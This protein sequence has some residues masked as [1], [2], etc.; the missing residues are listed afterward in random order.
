MCPSAFKTGLPRKIRNW[1]V[2][3]TISVI[4]I[5]SLVLI[6]WQFDISFF[7]RPLPDSKAMNPVAAVAF[8]FA[9][10]SFFALTSEPLAIRKLRTGIF[11]AALVLLI[12]TLKLISIVFS[13]DFY[14]DILLFQNKLGSDRMVPIAAINFMLTGI[15]LLLLHTK[16]KR[17][18]VTLNA[19]LLLIAGTSLFS[20]LGY[21]YQ[22]R[23][24]YGPFTYLPMAIHA[25]LGFLFLSVAMLFFNS[26]K[27]LMTEITGS[28]TGSITARKLIPVAILVPVL[29]GLLL[30]IGHWTNRFTPEFGVTILVFS[31]ILVLMGFIWHNVV[32]LN[33]REFQSR[34]AENALSEREEQIQTIFKAAPDAVIVIDH[35]GCI[36]QWNAKAELIFGWSSDEIIGKL[37][38]ETIIPERYREA[39][40]EGL[41]RFMRTG[42]GPV[43]NKTIEIQAINR[44]KIEFDVSLSISPT[45]VNEKQL[46]IGFI[47]DITEWKIAERKLEDNQKI[48]STVFFK[49]PVINSIADANTGKLIE[50]NDNFVNFCG[51]TKEEIIG[52]STLEL[53]LIPDPEQRADIINTI[54]EKGS[55]RDVVMQV[56]AKNGETKWVSTSAH[57]VNI[58]GR[59]CFLTAMIDVTERKLADEKLLTLSQELER[60]V[61]ERTKELAKSEKLFRAMIEKDTDMK[62][63]ATPDGKVFYV[64]PSLTTILGFDYHKLMAIP[65]FELIHPDDVAGL[66]KG[67]KDIV[68]TSGKSFYRQ[69]RLKHKNGTWLWCE[70]TIT[71]M[72]HEPAVAALVWNFRDITERKQVEEALLENQQLLAAI[73][74]NSAAVIYVKDL[75]GRYLLVNRRFSELFHRSEEEIMGKT[76]Y[77]FFLKEEADAFRQ[78]DI[79]TA[80]SDHALTEEERV[81]QDDGLHTYISVKSTLRNT[82]G[83][84]YAIF[85]ISTDITDQK[86]A[87]L[88]VQKLND[89]LEQKVINRTAELQSAN[90][91]L[92]SFSYSVSH[93]LRAPLRIIDGYSKIVAEDYADKLDAEANRMLNIIMANAQKMGNLIDDLLNFSRLER[94]E[95]IMHYV[96]MT[97]LVKSVIAEQQLLKAN[98]A[99]MHLE[100][101]E[102]ARCDNNLIQQVWANFISNAIKYSHEK[103]KPVIEINSRKTAHEIIYSIKDN[104]VGFDMQYADKLFGVFQRLHSAEE[105]EGTG[106]G[107]ALVQKIVSR[108][109][110]RVWADAEV[111]KGATFYF[112]LPIIQFN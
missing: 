21:L 38:S 62:I 59:E 73:I 4:T 68:Q 25:A 79:R 22:V 70:G 2:F 95:L 13:L 44:D 46:F 81:P 27:G 87:Q 24:F 32:L 41:H 53:N 48:F 100:K 11:F 74:N 78:M 12:G 20:I 102:P 83:K 40:K 6:G 66:M 9:S 72:L 31:I 23:I 28:L 67:I 39:H 93:D 108:H 65:A 60:K 85:G 51:F 98:H 61:I 84:P 91:E 88:E 111:D 97:E 47:R 43:I 16:T 7:Q 86:K 112:S 107:L 101:L 52:K 106:V 99:V 55:V 30:M 3:L 1:S 34:R 58:N 71:N 36:T 92:E 8:I 49:S 50:V 33:K 15:A 57:A 90:K 105:F 17:K 56:E 42:E 26:D 69:H 10:F 35:N 77:D 64:S 110:G 96:N 76:D 89:E 54:K 82:T 19:I 5:G 104:G 94:K 109:G 14:V 80:A 63:L 45:T 29:L 18:R 37:V 103:K 75:Q